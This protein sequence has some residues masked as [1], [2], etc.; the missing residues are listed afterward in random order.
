ME[1][2]KTQTAW[3]RPSAREREDMQA[4]LLRRVVNAAPWVAGMLFALALTKP[5]AEP[6]VPRSVLLALSGGDAVSAVA[7]M[8]ARAGIRRDLI[9]PRHADLATAALLALFT[10]DA[11]LHA[12]ILGKS[13][14]AEAISFV[15]VMVGGA[16]FLVDVRWFVALVVA[17]VSAWTIATLA[18]GVPALE[19]TRVIAIH[20]ATAA[21]VA[22]ILFALQGRTLL[23]AE[24]MRALA[25]ERA[26]R[27]EAL[28]SELAERNRDL[29]AFAYTA[30]HDLKAPL[31]A[32]GVHT[33]ALLEGPEPALD[34]A[35][36]ARV[37]KIQK[38]SAR[39][40]R[41]VE[42]LLALARM[43]REAL[44]IG[45]V[46]VSRLASEVVEALRAEAPER[47][48]EVR[49]EPGLVAQ[50][51]E[52]MVRTVLE[53]LL[54]NAW[55]YTRTRERALVEVG[56][57]ETPQGT[58]FF[59]RDDGIGFPAAQAAEAFQPFHR[60]SGAAGFE[61]TGVGLA[62]VKRIVERHGGAAWARAEPGVGATFWFTLPR[63]EAQE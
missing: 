35:S 51:D 45:P 43:G 37:E 19:I 22:S 9:R 16:V 38:E 3:V 53:N 26:G 4:V 57:A 41:L 24:R 60:L 30:S 48:V 49:I 17:D 54:G 1:G 25:D 39:L 6:A 36:R 32:V 2:A 61:G 15:L 58:A 56:Q 23:Q 27:A 10:A 55:K 59:V 29:E 52:A 33:E 8:A 12:V 5:W 42:D 40:V 20:M 34:P 44:S 47:S 28:A 18:S 13:P 50:A 46:D 63:R 7:M 14:E 62:S 11:T 31:R 21:V